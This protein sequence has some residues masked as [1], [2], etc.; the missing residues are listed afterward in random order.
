L[1]NAKLAQ[2]NATKFA[3][4]SRQAEELAQQAQGLA[5][6]AEQDRDETRLANERLRQAN[7]AADMILARQAWAA[8][9]MR[10]ARDLLD[11][12]R[13]AEGQVDLRGMEWHYLD[14]LCRQRL[15]LT[16]ECSAP[17]VQVAISP[18]GSRIAA[19]LQNG[20][21][22]VFDAQ[23]GDPIGEAMRV[24]QRR[25][26][27]IAFSADGRRLA[28][29]GGTA[30][31]VFDLTSGKSL[32][33]PAPEGPWGVAFDPD[34]KCLVAGLGDGSVKIWPLDNSPEPPLLEGHTGRIFDL[35][36]S[37]D[38]KFLASGGRDGTV[39]LRNAKTWERVELAPIERDS[40]GVLCVAFDGGSRLLAAA[41]ADGVI[42]IW[43]VRSG[44]SALETPIK[45]T[46]M[47]HSI[48][49]S[50]NGKR[51]AAAGAQQSIHLFD[52]QTGKALTSWRAHSSVV[53]ELAFSTDGRRL[54]S[55][56]ADGAVR[57]WSTGEVVE[58]VRV[59]PRRYGGLSRWQ[60]AVSPDGALL[61]CTEVAGKVSLWDA[62]NWNDP[63]WKPLRTLEGPPVQ[64]HA[65]AFSPDSRRLAGGF[66]NGRLVLWDVQQETPVLTSS[67]QHSDQVLG[68]A[69]GPDGKF[70][71]SAARFRRRTVFDALRLWDAETAEAVHELGADSAGSGH[72]AAVNS[73]A[74]SPDGRWLA[75]GSGDQTVR[76]WSLETRRELPAL[77]AEHV[78][79][80]RC[81]AFSPDSRQLASASYDGTVMVR[82]VQTGRLL[83]RL[84]GHVGQVNS[85][86]YS[87]DGSR[88]ASGSSDRTIKVW[89]A[90]T[91]QELLTLEGHSG[92]VTCLAFSA[93][94]RRLFSLC[95]S[96]TLRVWDGTPLGGDS[97]K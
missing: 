4:K 32:R 30:V 17:V 53:Q 77:R 59:G 94:G 68:V 54:I 35:V 71:A 48:A 5:R 89:D 24:Y 90:A 61:A 26:R 49:L 66:A 72:T 3:L 40:G 14:Q 43:D 9:D 57:I 2:Q 34:G 62:N 82:D 10:R 1:A 69:F 86:C 18:D 42:R 78:D 31:Y 91:G 64:V 51:L 41:G 23:S 15:L 6:A 22:E 8:S 13:P 75:S 67:Q 16:K 81:V 50:P 92:S 38:G 36:F 12:H 20:T 25:I 27:A 97:L 28:F 39:I 65:L 60:L 88:I 80:V 85:V 56:G 93:D 11:A 37:P 19:G 21:A 84:E 58:S 63:N 87:R 74:L 44:K 29:S 73:V 76:L 7:Y 96:R 70:L 45:L 46:G 52:T 55:G 95:S 47:I 79:A 33:W 83:F